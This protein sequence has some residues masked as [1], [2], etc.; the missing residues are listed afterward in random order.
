MLSTR[1]R[2]VI[3]L[4]VTEAEWFE[5]EAGQV[6]LAGFDAIDN[7]QYA[8]RIASVGRVPEVQQG[9]VT[10]S[11][12]AAILTPGEL[13]AVENELVSIGGQGAVTIGAEGATGGR[14]GGINPQARA[15]LEAFAAQVTLPAGVEILDV[16]RALAFDEPLPEGVVLPDGFEIPQQFK[17]RLRCRIR[18]GRPPR[19]RARGRRRCQRTA[20]RAGH[21][22]Q[23]HHPH[24]DPS[25]SRPGFHL[26]SPTDRRRLLRRGPQR[27][28]RLG[29][30]RGRDSANRT[31]ATSRSSPAWRSG[32]TVLVGADTEGDRLRRHPALF[33]ARRTAG[34]PA[35]GVGQGAGAPR[36]GGQ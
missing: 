24:S 21:E 1:N 34:G 33:R 32:A 22:R 29:T 3:D 7:L 20:A 27:R 10:Y 28:R 11:V 35:G 5:L 25:R 16:V 18:S 17:A 36:G 8:V 19:G 30:S 31:A 14:G 12:E 13:S 26:R 4:T 23:R 6:G 15:A 2:I 9:V